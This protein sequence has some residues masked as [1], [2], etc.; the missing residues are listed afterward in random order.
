MFVNHQ[1]ISVYF[2]RMT[3]RFGINGAGKLH[4]E[5]LRG[6]ITPEVRRKIRQVVTKPQVKQSVKH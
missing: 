5:L 2:D 1:K 6:E 4:Q 3:E